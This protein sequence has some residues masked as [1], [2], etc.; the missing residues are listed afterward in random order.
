MPAV[1]DVQNIAQCR[2][3]RRGHNAD[4]AGQRGN[5]FLA[6]S[7]E[8]AFGFQLGLELFKRNLERARALRF[9]VF[10]RNLQFATVLV[11][12]HPAANH[13]LHA[14]FRTKPQ[15]ARL[16]AEHHDADL[17]TLVFQRE[18]EMAGIMGAEIG[19]L[20]F[21]PGVG[22]L[23]LNVG[24]DR[25]DQLAYCPY[26]AAWGFETEVELVGGGHCTAV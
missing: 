24:A 4:A 13:H 17:R 6:G 10:R 21:H 7:V 2:G 20:A 3:L 12:G 14:I 15:Q 5:R 1:Q 16:R 8:Q 25:C 26:A 19:D 18:V 9:Q 11:D 23:A 22:E